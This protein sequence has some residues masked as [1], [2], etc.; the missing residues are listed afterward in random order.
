MRGFVVPE[1]AE[2]KGRCGEDSYDYARIAPPPLDRAGTWLG[3][4]VEA[5]TL[6]VSSSCLRG[7]RRRVSAP[8]QNSKY[9]PSGQPASSQSWKARQEI[10]FPFDSIPDTQF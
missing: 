2:Q 8:I 3:R 5:F 6:P 7:A 4:D 10:S 9:R 1:E